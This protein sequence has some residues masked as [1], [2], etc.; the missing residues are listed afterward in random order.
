[1]KGF[2]EHEVAL[3]HLSSKDLSKLFGSF[4]FQK[5]RENK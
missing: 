5:P 4:M 2:L 1:M 3:K